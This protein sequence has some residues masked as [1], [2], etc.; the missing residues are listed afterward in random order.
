MMGIKVVIADDHRLILQS[1]RGALERSEDFEV[2]GETDSGAHVLPLVSRTNP[3]LV[4]MDVHMPGMDGLSCLDMIR[5]RYPTTK[6]VLISASSDPE[7][8]QA[9]LRRGADGYIVKSINPDDIPAALRQ[10]YEGTAYYAL[11]VSESAEEHVSRTVGLTEREVTILKALARGLSNK[12]ISQEHW[13]TE[14]TVKFHLSN[15]YRKLGVANRAEAMRY[16]HQQGIA[17]SEAVQGQS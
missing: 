16:A 17:G 7:Q 15:I 4:L 8:I 11:G 14:Q 6:V 1:L 9:V 2:V 5:K 10:A 12:Q 13:V 3:D